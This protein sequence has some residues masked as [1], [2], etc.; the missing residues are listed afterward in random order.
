[1]RIEGTREERESDRDFWVAKE[2]HG[3]YAIHTE[4]TDEEIDS[5]ITLDGPFTY[6]EA[7]ANM[8]EAVSG[9]WDD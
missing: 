2:S 9:A 4:P 6:D 1:M 3:G 8:Q 7:I 5:F